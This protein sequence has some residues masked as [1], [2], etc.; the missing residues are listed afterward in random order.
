[1]C[2]AT[3]RDLAAIVGTADEV[4]VTMSMV[5]FLIQGL[6]ASPHCEGGR[7]WFSGCH[8]RRAWAGSE[9]HVRDIQQT[10]AYLGEGPVVVQ[11]LGESAT[12]SLDGLCRR[13]ALHLR[14]Q[15]LQL[16]LWRS[17]SWA[18]KK[19]SQERSWRMWLSMK[20]ALPLVLTLYPD[21]LRRHTGN[22]V[23]KIQTISM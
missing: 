20:T 1:M 16:Y 10:S 8:G 4:I 13:G 11:G 21:W 7:T 23:S 14:L 3:G 18:S 6:P 17:S 22:S 2:P 12:V 19:S 5:A 15:L 9:K